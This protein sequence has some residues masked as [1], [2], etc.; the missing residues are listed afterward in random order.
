MGGKVF[1]AGELR[2]R[3]RP[4]FYLIFL[5]VALVTGSLPA[6]PRPAVVSLLGLIREPAGRLLLQRTFPLLLRPGLVGDGVGSYRYYSYSLIRLGLL[7]L[8]APAG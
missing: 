3:L 7:G 5:Q 2:L 8:L 1:I 4:T 6:P